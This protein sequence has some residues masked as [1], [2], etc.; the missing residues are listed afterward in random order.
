MTQRAIDELGIEPTNASYILSIIGVFNTLARVFTGWLSDQPW[1]DAL[2]I[3][4][5]SVILAG[6]ATCLVPVLNSYAL[7]CIYG[8]CFGVFIGLFTVSS[9]YTA[10]LWLL[11]NYTVVF[12]CVRSCT[13]VGSLQTCTKVG[14]LQTDCHINLVIL[15]SIRL[16]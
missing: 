13:K 5:V 2:L 3:H 10:I 14:S 9:C 11:Y 8:A 12:N 4:N 15:Y 16:P 6:V 7:L 1:A